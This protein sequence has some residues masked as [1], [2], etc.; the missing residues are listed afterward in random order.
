MEKVTEH[1]RII[2]DIKELLEKII[3]KVMA[4]IHGLIL[5]PMKVNDIKIKFM[6]L[7]K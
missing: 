7:V 5:E 3:Y 1:S 6:E 4:F 2:V